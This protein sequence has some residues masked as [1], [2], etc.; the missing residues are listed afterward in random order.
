M[1]NKSRPS[2]GLDVPYSKTIYGLLKEPWRLI[3]WSIAL[4]EAKLRPFITLNQQLI[5]EKNK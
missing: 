1:F 2:A 4:F 5:G 3:D